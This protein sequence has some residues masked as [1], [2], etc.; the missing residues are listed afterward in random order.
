MCCCKTRV[1]SIH[2][3][4]AKHKHRHHKTLTTKHTLNHRLTVISPSSQSDEQ[5]CRVDV[6]VAQNNKELHQAMFIAVLNR[7]QSQLYNGILM[8]REKYRSHLKQHH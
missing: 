4:L 8:S 1:Q 5:C 6:A 7:Q 2:Q 3:V